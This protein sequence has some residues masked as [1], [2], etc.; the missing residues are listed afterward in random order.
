MYKSAHFGV[1]SW[2]AIGQALGKI[3]PEVTVPELLS[4]QP[5]QRQNL[6]KSLAEIKQ[7]I[8]LAWNDVLDDDAWR[9]INMLAI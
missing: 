5:E 6:A 3:S 2:F 8:G 4:L 9:F 7:R 1:Y